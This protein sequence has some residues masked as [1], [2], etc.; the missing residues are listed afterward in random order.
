MRLLDAG[1]LCV[2]TSDRRRLV[3]FAVAMRIMLHQLRS[4]VP[5]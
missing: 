1:A 3:D 4:V 5:A 2:V